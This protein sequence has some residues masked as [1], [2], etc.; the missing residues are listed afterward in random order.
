MF[1]DD[2]SRSPFNDGFHKLYSVLSWFEVFGFGCLVPGSRFQVLVSGCL[3][4]VSAI[5]GYLLEKVRL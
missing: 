3:V 2:H 4:P 5:H 1:F